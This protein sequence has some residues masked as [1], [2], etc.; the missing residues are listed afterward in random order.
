MHPLRNGLLLAASLAAVTGCGG[1]T[2]SLDE[3]SPVPEAPAFQTISGTISGLEGSL[4]LGWGDR[5]QTL[6]GDSFS[7]PFAFEAGEDFDL[8][9]VN[10]PLSQ[11]CTIAGQT[12]FNDQDGDIAGVAISCITQNLIRVTVENFFS[13]EP[14]EGI[15][16]TAI[17]NNGSQQTLSGVSDAEGRLTLEVPTF[18]G[19]IVVNAD[20]DGFGEQSKIV[21]NTSIP[22][23]RTARMLMQ[24][25]VLGTTFDS[26]LGTDLTVGGDVLVSIPANALV[27]E[28]DTL[29]NGTVT[30]ELTVV[31]PSVSVE[32]MPGDYTS[33]DPGGSTSPIQ[34]YGAISVTFTG[35]NG[36]VLDLEAGRM[37]D[38]N[39]PV[40]EAERAGP[41][42]ATP[43][44]HYDRQTG[45]WIEEGTANLTTLAS[46]LQ[47]YAGQVSHFTT[48]NADEAYVPVYINGCVQTL[49]G[50]PYPNVRVDATGV[51]YLGSSRAI[52]NGNGQFSIPARPWSEVLI[53]VGDGLQSGTSQVSTGTSDST[54]TDCLVASAGS[55]TINLTW[56]ENPRDLDTR[57]Y[58]FSAD[59]TADDFEVNFTQRSVTT[60]AIS[61]DLDVDDTN[62]FGP[63]IVTFPDFPYPGVYRY[64]VHLYSGT[65]T[66]QDSPARVEVNLRGTVTVFTPPGG[67]PTDCW[68]V[69]DVEVDEFGNLT[70]IPL[71]SWEAESYCTSGDFANPITNA[72]GGSVA[73][74]VGETPNN[75]LLKMIEKKYYR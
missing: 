24:P 44:F 36:E 35:S 30:T 28:S 3:F 23:G 74:S 51:D 49:T 26:A 61:V 50:A 52:T 7:I 40:A 55:S 20:P 67:T 2:R 73:L 60:G 25:V 14:L 58:G 48:W 68:A 16:I 41:P 10:E 69:L 17:W 42:A 65:G 75:P 53:T 11:R 63:E 47:V 29:Y 13:G 21:T 37:A 22:A 31:D 66:I 39:I 27:D 4:I 1:D 12:A 71:D 6:S 38:I 70:S 32:I 33:R 46:G 62:G 5:E 8:T 54:T 45:Y 64:A 15:D 72:P 34:S 19:R 18:D 59:N 43:L 9:I 56:G 57:L